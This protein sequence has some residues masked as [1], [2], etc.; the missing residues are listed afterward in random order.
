VNGEVV[1]ADEA[2]LI[3]NGTRDGRN[4]G[5]GG[6]RGGEQGEGTITNA[7]TAVWVFGR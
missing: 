2:R 1:Q 7:E 6:E 4:A 5:Q 3:D